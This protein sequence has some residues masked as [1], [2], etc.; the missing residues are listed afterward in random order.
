M[1]SAVSHR[2]EHDRRKRHLAD[3]DAE[4]NCLDNERNWT[5]SKEFYSIL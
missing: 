2:E 1:P 4:K 5:W 3:N